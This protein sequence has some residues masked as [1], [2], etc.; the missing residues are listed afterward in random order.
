MSP[1]G[2]VK[3]GHRRSAQTREVSAEGFRDCRT[4]DSRSFSS[5]G[6]ARCPMAPMSFALLPTLRS[7]LKCWA[8]EELQSL[9]KAGKHR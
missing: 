2:G 9:L 7:A 1:H 5:K 3:H 6:L 8:A 4:I